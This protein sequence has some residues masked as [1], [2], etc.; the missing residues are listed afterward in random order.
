VRAQLCSLARWLRLALACLA[1]GSM[2]SPAQVASAA[3]R[4]GVVQGGAGNKPIAV[5]SAVA[6][7]PLRARA[8]IAEAQALPTRLVHST[9]ARASRH[10]LFLLHR[11]LLR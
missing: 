4:A 5:V 2:V 8:F 10:A 9:E 3:E 6:P 7:S 11:A 1:V